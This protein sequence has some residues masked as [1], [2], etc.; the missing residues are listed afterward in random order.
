MPCSPS[1]ATSH[2]IIFEGS[3]F[4]PCTTALANA[5]VNASS[6]SS[7]ASRSAVDVPHNIHHA[8]D[9]GIHCIAVGSERYAEFEIK[10]VCI[11]IAGLRQAAVP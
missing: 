7:F 5:S 2:S 10:L 6:M 8:L 3:F 9:N 1:Q 11:E 4:A